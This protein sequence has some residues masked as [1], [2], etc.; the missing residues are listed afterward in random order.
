M[1]CWYCPHRLRDLNQIKYLPKQ[2]FLHNQSITNTRENQALCEFPQ[3]V[4]S[5]IRD[6]RNYH[7]AQH[8]FPTT[9]CI[10]CIFSRFVFKGQVQESFNLFLLI[11]NKRIFEVDGSQFKLQFGA[12]YYC[13]SKTLALFCSRSIKT[14]CNSLIRHFRC[15]WTLS[16]RPGPGTSR[17][18][19]WHGPDW[20]TL[21]WLW[22]EPSEMSQPDIDS[23]SGRVISAPL[24]MLIIWFSQMK[25]V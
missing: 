19:G 9:V 23:R 18:T 1:Y 17:K 10:G 13:S 2:Q 11:H 5:G 20:C 8:F 14:E 12:A 22:T 16:A 3:C 7:R 15:W 6:I 25:T 24:R 21:S 4:D